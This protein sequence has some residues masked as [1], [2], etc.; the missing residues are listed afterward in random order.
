MPLP[1]PGEGFRLMN[2]GDVIAVGDAAWLIGDGRDLEWIPVE[3][4]Y[5]HIIGQNYSAGFVPFR[6]PIHKENKTMA[7]TYR[8]RGDPIDFTTVG[9]YAFLLGEFPGDEDHWSRFSSLPSRPSQLL[10]PDRELNLRWVDT[11]D[12]TTRKKTK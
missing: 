7:L 6:T 9:W 11:T 3:G 2:P 5:S 1:D 12:L 4:N 10:T 8:F